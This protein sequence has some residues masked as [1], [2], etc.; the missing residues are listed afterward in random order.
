MI[1]EDD[2]MSL[3]MLRALPE[4]AAALRKIEELKKKLEDGF[5]KV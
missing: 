3:P 2:V 5:P 1:D 4:L